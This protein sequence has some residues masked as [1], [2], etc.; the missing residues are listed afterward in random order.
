MPRRL[1]ALLLALVLAGC[2][3]APTPGDDGPEDADLVDFSHLEASG[4]TI[5]DANN[6]RS[7]MWD[8]TVGV[9]GNIPLLGTAPQSASATYTFPV[10]RN[11]GFVEVTL[12]TLDAAS[13]VFMVR[14]ETERVGCGGGANGR[15][16]T[17]P[18][19]SGVTG[20]LDWSVLIQSR[21]ND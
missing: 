15:S 8:G 14:N 11:V 7:F 18:V 9:G 10:D 1:L 2:A 21:Q 6:T 20:V 17:T 16:C 13:L 12:E 19:P 3:K 4:A 5:E